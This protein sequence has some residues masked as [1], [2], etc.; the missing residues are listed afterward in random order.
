MG[1]I[2]AAQTLGENFVNHV[3]ESGTARSSILRLLF[4]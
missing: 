2:K 3:K 1:E 4:S